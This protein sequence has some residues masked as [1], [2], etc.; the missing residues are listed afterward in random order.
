M[1][2]PEK[3]PPALISLAFTAAIQ[4]GLI[5]LGLVA[6]IGLAIRLPSGD[7]LVPLLLLQVI[8]ALIMG[9]YTLYWLKLNMFQT[10]GGLAPLAAA[11]LLCGSKALS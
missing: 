2:E 3:R 6:K 1:R 9:L 10:L 5:P 11:A 7:K 8:I 4:A